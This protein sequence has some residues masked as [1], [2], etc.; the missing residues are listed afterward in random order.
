MAHNAVA[1]TSS[2]AKTL[3]AKLMTSGTEIRLAAEESHITSK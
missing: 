3:I 1:T 2:G